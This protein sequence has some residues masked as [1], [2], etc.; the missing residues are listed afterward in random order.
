MGKLLVD[1]YTCA[2]KDSGPLETTFPGQITQSKCKQMIEFLSKNRNGV[3]LEAGLPEDVRIAHKH[4]WTTESDGL[5]HTISDAG[6]IYSPGGTYILTIYIHDREQLLWERMNFM[7]ALL[8]Q[9]V[10]NFYNLP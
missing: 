9:T 8:S 5:I 2:E 6:I 3:L 10:Y 1:I 4:G 7:I